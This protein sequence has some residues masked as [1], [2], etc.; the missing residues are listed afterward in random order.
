MKK[1][2]AIGIDIGGAALKC[3]LIDKNGHI[4]FLNISLGQA[5]T[6]ADI[7]QLVERAVIKCVAASDGIVSGVGVGFPGVVDNG[8]VIGGGVNLPR[9]RNIMMNT[10]ICIK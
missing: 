9:C 4:H 10:K 7:I 3:G 6:S 8:L 5:S 1:K 2:Y